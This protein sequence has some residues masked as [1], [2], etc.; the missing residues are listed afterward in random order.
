MMLLPACGDTAAFSVRG[1][2]DAESLPLPVPLS[3]R[4][5]GSLAQQI[6]SQD[7]ARHGHVP[8][9]MTAEKVPDEVFPDLSF[10]SCAEGFSELCHDLP[11]SF[12]ACQVRELEW[13]S[14]HMFHRYRAWFPAHT[15]RPL[16]Q[17]H[18]VLPVSQPMSARWLCLETLPSET[19]HTPLPMLRPRELRVVARPTS[20]EKYQSDQPLRPLI[21]SLLRGSRCFN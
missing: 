1:C 18:P 20:T 14:V 8:R 21:K 7:V 10:Q 9:S 5:D 19:S 17:S 3:S 6:L 15:N 4:P 12:V 13:F 11:V 2:R 16:Q